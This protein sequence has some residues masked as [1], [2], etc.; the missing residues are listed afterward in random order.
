MCSL[1]A[2]THPHRQPARRWLSSA[3]TGHV[4][5]HP[6]SLLRGPRSLPAGCVIY[7]GATLVHTTHRLFEYRVLFLCVH[8]G[9]LAAKFARCLAEPC[10]VALG[11]QC[12]IFPHDT[13]RI[14]RLF[15][16]EHPYRTHK[17]LLGR[18]AVWPDHGEPKS[19]GK[20]LAE[21]FDAPTRTVSRASLTCQVSW[22][23][24]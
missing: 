8:C 21:A 2:G 15:A 14:K 4:F 13:I 23:H 18:P 17:R 20:I 16:G 6:S 22:L 5:A 9:A 24:G 3:C 7:V 19:L 1:P 12:N 10:P 11:L